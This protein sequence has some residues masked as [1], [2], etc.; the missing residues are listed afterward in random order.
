V[1]NVLSPVLFKMALDQIPPKAVVLE[2]APH[3][4]LQAILKRSVSQGKILGLTNKNAGDHINFFLTNL[5][6]LFLHG[7]EP[8]VSQLYPKVEFPVGNS[9][10]MISPLISWDHSTTWKVAGYVEDI[11][12]DCV[13]VYEVSLKNKPDVF[14]AG[15]QINSRVIFPATGFLFLVWKAFARRQRTTF[16]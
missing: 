2:L 3:S 5:G 1:N 9:V 8:R 11:P 14:Y 13:S 6:K 15:H 12:I 7:L 16:S 4:L 10:R